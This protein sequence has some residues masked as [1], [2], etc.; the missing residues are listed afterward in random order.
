[1]EKYKLGLLFAG[2][3]ISDSERFRVGKEIEKVG[4]LTFKVD[5]C[6]DGWSAECNEIGGIIA[7]NSNSKPTDAEIESE[8]RNAILSAFDVK[9]EENSIE[10]PYK[11]E[12]QVVPQVTN[13]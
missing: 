2:L 12:Y 9:F 7:G 11:F 10:S 8:I 6:E 4:G 1:M 5:I 13:C 3:P